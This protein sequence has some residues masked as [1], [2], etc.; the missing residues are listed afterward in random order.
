MGCGL[1]TGEEYP[2][3]RIR[4]KSMNCGHHTPVMLPCPWEKVGQNVLHTGTAF[5]LRPFDRN[6]AGPAGDGGARDALLSN[7]CRWAG[8]RWGC[9]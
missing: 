5:N 1:A 9:I 2:A 6:T 7:T 4:V 8:R 3:F